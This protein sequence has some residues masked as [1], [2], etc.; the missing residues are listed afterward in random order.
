MGK[1]RA[2]VGGGVGKTVKRPR[3]PPA[4]PERRGQRVAPARSR[5]AHPL[6][7]VPA[8]GGGRATRTAVSERARARARDPQGL[9]SS[10]V[11][12]AGA[13]TECEPG[14]P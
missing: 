6:W 10:R 1:G 11:S 13:G 8:R 3:E 9:G 5:P 12:R 14:R 2:G 7:R 4:R